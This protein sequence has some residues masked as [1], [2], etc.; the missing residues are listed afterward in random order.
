MPVVAVDGDNQRL[1]SSI[2]G[3]LRAENL[4]RAFSQ[5]DGSVEARAE[6]W[7][8]LPTSSTRS[9]AIHDSDVDSLA[10][11]HA[12]AAE[13]GHEVSIVARHD[14]VPLVDCVCPAHAPSVATVILGQRTVPTPR[15]AIPPQGFAAGICGGR[16]ASG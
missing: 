11:L 5:I 3:E 13:L 15:A 14:E 9:V 2:A 1:D 10:V 8:L 6:R 16:S 4:A 7:Q 12:V